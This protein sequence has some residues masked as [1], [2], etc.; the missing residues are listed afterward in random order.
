MI[1]PFWLPSRVRRQERFVPLKSLL[2]T[3]L[4]A[5][6]IGAR[7]RYLVDDAGIGTLRS[8]RQFFLGVCYDAHH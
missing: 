4:A 2:T 8:T 6:T 7:F 5:E 1:F 3:S